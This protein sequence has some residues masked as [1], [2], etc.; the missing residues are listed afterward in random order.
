SQVQLA[1]NDF[2]GQTGFFIERSTDNLNFSQIASTVL[3]G[4]ADH[5]GLVDLAD[6]DIWF[7]HLQSSNCT[8]SHGDFN[9]DGL[10][11]LSDFDIW[12]NNLHLS[13]AA[14]PNPTSFLDSTLH[15][16]TTYYYR[17][18]A[19]TPSTISPYSSTLS[20]TTPSTP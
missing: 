2:A 6:F 9:N 4:D 7:T 11:D 17:I 14:P 13:Y 8:F 18:R 15:P 5:S 3:P 16:D 1:W 19:A 10:V 12:F 20:V